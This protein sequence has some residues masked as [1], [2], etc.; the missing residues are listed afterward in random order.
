MSLKLLQGGNKPKGYRAKSKEDLEPIVCPRCQGAVFEQVIV[1]P[2]RRG[3]RHDKRTG[4]KR[5]R[6]AVKS[7][8][9]WCD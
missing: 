9:E 7:C 1:N 8:G 3:L 5:L 4:T 2:M 6:C